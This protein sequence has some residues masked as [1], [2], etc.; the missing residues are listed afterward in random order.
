MKTIFI[1]GASGF[2]GSNIVNSLKY[3]FIQNS[4]NSK[5]NILDIQSL[6]KM[7]KEI[8]TVIHLAAKTYVPD[9]FKK[10]YEFYKFNLESTLNMLEFC[11]YKKVKKF[12]YVNTYPY[13]NPEYLPID[14]NH[15][16]RLHSPYHKSKHLAEKL[17]FYYLNNEATKVISLRLFNIFGI[18]EN[19][20]MLIST[21]IRQAINEKNIK[22]KSLEPKRDYIYINDFVSLI[23]KIIKKQIK[24]GVYNVGSGKS[25]SVK[26][27]AY[28]ILKVLG[29]SKKVID[30]GESRK[31]EIMDCVADITKISKEVDWKPRYTLEKA[32][33]DLLVD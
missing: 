20:K 14:E 33:K 4:I 23:D 9:S 13:G 8:D 29:L 32:L 18:H 15:P 7:E 24:S 11:K 6:K 12:I 25:Y 31:G 30:L 2:I 22:L 26:E 28:E 10:P 3:N 5:I 1:S 19:P 27:I 21:I 16:I 17:S